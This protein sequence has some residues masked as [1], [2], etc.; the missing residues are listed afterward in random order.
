MVQWVLV[1]RTKKFETFIIILLRTGPEDVREGGWKYL[2]QIVSMLGLN[3][4][5]L[6]LDQCRRC[7]TLNWI[8]VV[9]R[10]QI[11]EQSI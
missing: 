3:S 1:E 9:C 10:K 4:A 6:A 5:S 11:E 2:S 7:K 8:I